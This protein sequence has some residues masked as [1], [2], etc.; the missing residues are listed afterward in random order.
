MIFFIRISLST[1]VILTLSLMFGPLFF[2]CEY[3]HS[4]YNSNLT[5]QIL[6]VTILLLSAF[7]YCKSGS[8]FHKGNQHSLSVATLT[9]ILLSTGVII[10][11]IYLDQHNPKITHYVIFI[12][13]SI[14]YIAIL[15]KWF[16][17]YKKLKKT[18]VGEK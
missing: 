12:I 13:I 8:L 15:I 14:A 7:L 16:S 6:N 2:E 10:R 9:T 4:A 3:F 18:H 11:D 5:T 17:L 1:L